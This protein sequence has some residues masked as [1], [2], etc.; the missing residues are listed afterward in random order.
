MSRVL[1]TWHKVVA[2]R[3]S[4]LLDDLLADT[5]VFFSPVVHTPQEG[6]ARTKLYLSAAITVFGD[7]FRYVRELVGDHQAVLEFMA[8][9]DGIQING[10]D[11]ID[12]D[13]QGRITQFKVMIRPLKAVN[14]LHQQMRTM[15]AS[16]AAGAGQ[17]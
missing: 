13:A 5:C 9:N 11:I 1:D 8:E 10:V 6:R 14:L 12:W 17:R 16:L 7:S 2:T 3:N 4:D 15:L